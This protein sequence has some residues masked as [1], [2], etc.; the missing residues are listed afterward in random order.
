M[1][2]YIQFDSLFFFTKVHARDHEISVGICF[3]HGAQKNRRIT[4]PCFCK[5]ETNAT[6]AVYRDQSLPGHRVDCAADTR[7]AISS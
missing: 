7:T 6:F 5:L 2:Y 3:F 1:N 4:Q